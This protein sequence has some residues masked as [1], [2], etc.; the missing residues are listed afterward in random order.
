MNEIGTAGLHLLDD[1]NRLAKAE[2]GRV[3]A[4]TQPVQHQHVQALKQLKRLCRNGL[5]VCDIGEVA[6]SVARDW[7]AP[8]E[9]RNRHYVLAQRLERPGHLMQME[10]WLPPVKGKRIYEGV[11]EPIAQDSGSRGVGIDRQMLLLN[12]V[13]AAEIVEPTRVVCV[14]VGHEHR[15]Y[16]CQAVRER[17][18]AEF[19]GGVN[20]ERDAARAYDGRGA[21]AFIS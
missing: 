21:R 11:G 13:E 7:Q 16:L 14:G 1:L 3:F 17:L 15:V 9:H 10:I 19:R 18:S 8:M 2:V 5:G 20:Q 4:L 12:L 6:N